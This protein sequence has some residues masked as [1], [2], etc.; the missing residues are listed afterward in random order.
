ML[1][2]APGVEWESLVTDVLKK[3]TTLAERQ[4][5][6]NALL[7]QRLGPGDAAAVLMMSLSE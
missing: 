3:S 4:Q 7:G 6:L 1:A 2:Y 5:T